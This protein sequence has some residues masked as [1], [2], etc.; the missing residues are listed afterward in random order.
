MN[1][2]NARLQAINERKQTDAESRLLSSSTSKVTRVETPG[3]AG[4]KNWKD[5]CISY[6]REIIADIIFIRSSSPVVDA[7]HS[8]SRFPILRSGSNLLIIAIYLSTT[9]SFPTTT[10]PSLRPIADL[11][12]FGRSFAFHDDLPPYS[13]CGRRRMHRTRLQ[14]LSYATS[15]RK[16]PVLQIGGRRSS[17]QRTTPKYSTQFATTIASSLQRTIPSTR[18]GAV[19]VVLQVNTS[20]VHRR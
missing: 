4:M 1:L 19:P 20:K 18:P 16:I 3:N 13:S 10:Y 2:L 12:T 9:T 5:Q 15:C 7:I 14:E 6:G 17:K 8:C 11:P